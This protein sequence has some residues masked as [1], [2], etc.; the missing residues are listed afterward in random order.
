MQESNCYVDLGNQLFYLTRNNNIV[1]I[2]SDKNIFDFKEV[3]FK[4]EA[5]F[6]HLKQNLNIKQKQL[7]SKNFLTSI[8]YL[9]ITLGI[10]DN[11]NLRCKYCIYS[12]IYPEERAHSNT[13]MSVE[14]V[15]NVV[16]FIKNNYLTL[17]ELDIVFYGGEPLL[18]IPLLKYSINL[19]K[20]S[21]LDTNINFVLITNG[22]AIDPEIIEL[23]KI[24]RF[25]VQLSLD[26]SKKDHD[27][28]RVNLQNIGSFDKVMNAYN[29]L[30]N[31]NIIPTF[32]CTLAPNANLNDVAD[33]F[34]SQFDDQT[35]SLTIGSLSP[36]YDQSL[37]KNSH[38]DKNDFE[39]NFHKYTMNKK[40]GSFLFYETILNS[41]FYVIKFRSNKDIFEDNLAD[42]FLC[43]AGYSR[44]YVTTSGE[45]SACVPFKD[46]KGI[47]GDID[48]I[49]FKNLENINTQYSEFKLKYCSKCW[50]VRLCQTCQGNI[51]FDRSDISIK[52][53]C[54]L[55]KK[56]I[57]KRLIDFIEL[58]NC[59]PDKLSMV[60]YI[61]ED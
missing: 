40:E 54:D 53:E 56:G 43:N 28:F 10:T 50:A 33:F 20:E 17:S 41:R 47:L 35:H 2:D 37:F 13:N 32:A 9:H 3:L 25:R 6:D 39:I 57:K 14:T 38:Y 59:N 7:S 18:N 8:Q 60:N 34:N 24:N 44:F 21:F 36:G 42:R 11:C 19:F 46:R 12:G 58:L 49:D 26:G 4:E 23:L 61:K 27:K 31:S 30:R 51:D 15:N 1:S 55:I 45:I 22:I 52:R 29:L 48:N 16:C 5:L